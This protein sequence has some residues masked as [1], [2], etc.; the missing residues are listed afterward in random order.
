MRVRLA[1]DAQPAHNLEIDHEGIVNTAGARANRVQLMGEWIR[2]LDFQADK[3]TEEPADH[4]ARMLSRKAHDVCL[5]VS[6]ARAYIH[7]Y[8]TR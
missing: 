3:D 7:T 8:D 5:L 2:P 4:A 1:Q 6:F